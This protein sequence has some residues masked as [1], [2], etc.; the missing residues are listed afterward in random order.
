M[1]VLLFA[2]GPGTGSEHH[3]PH[4]YIERD[5]VYTGTHDNNT[6]RGWFERDA[7]GEEKE[8]LFAYLGDRVRS[9]RVHE[10]MIRLALMSVAG[11]AVIP[12]Q[13]LLGLGE[14]ARMNLP[15]GK[16]SYWRWRLLPGQ[17]N[18]RLERRMLEMTRTYGR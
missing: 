5:F 1:R 16:G 10:A 3:A 13:D 18:G 17:L 11:T 14:K 8:R 6:V 9:E 2:F 4:N 7:T 12:M 15:A